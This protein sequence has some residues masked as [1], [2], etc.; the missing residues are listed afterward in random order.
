M[1]PNSPS[2]RDAAIGQLFSGSTYQHGL[3]VFICESIEIGR[4]YWMRCVSN[5]SVPRRNVSVRAIGATFHR[6]TEGADHWLLR[7][8]SRRMKN[9]GHS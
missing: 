8:G 1:A 6:V 4:G 5:P 9:A 2:S 3:Q 7:D